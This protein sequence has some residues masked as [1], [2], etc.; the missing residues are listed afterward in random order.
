MLSYLVLNYTLDILTSVWIERIVGV[1]L[2]E[3]N[4]EGSYLNPSRTSFRDLDK[5]IPNTDDGLGSE[6]IG[7]ERVNYTE[8]LHTRVSD[9]AGTPNPYPSLD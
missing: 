4:P 7:A 8:M 2:G 3:V 6:V 9:N 1:A 5:V